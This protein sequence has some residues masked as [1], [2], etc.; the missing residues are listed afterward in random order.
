MDDLYQEELM[1]IYKNPTHRG[2]MPNSAV[3]TYEKNPM[4]G[5]EI[6]LHLDVQDGVIK[7]AKFEGS[8]CAVSVISSEL[9]LEHIIGM[10]VIE[11]AKISKDEL[12]KL[13]NLS[14]V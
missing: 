2:S 6:T 7:D 10:S 9:L 4:C 11:T 8:A 1:E 13:L 12:I 5:D 3:H 14:L